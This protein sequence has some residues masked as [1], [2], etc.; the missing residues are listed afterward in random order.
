MSIKRKKSEMEN[1]VL[2]MMGYREDLQNL[3]MVKAMKGYT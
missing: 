3:V 2:G 1:A